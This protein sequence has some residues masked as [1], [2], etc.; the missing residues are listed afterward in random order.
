MKRSFNAI[1]IHIIFFVVVSNQAFGNDVN[2]DSKVGIDD[3][4]IALQVT[5]G[6][7]SQIYLPTEIKWAGDWE[8]HDRQYNKNDIVS[9]NGTSYI[10]VLPHISSDD[11]LPTNKALWDIV[12]LKGDTGSQGLKGDI[13]L[14]GIQGEKGNTGPQGIQGEKG[15]TGSQGLPPEHQW[16]GT[17]LRFQNTDGSWGSYV[18]L[19]GDKGESVDENQSTNGV[20]S[21]KTSN[22]ASPK[23][24]NHNLNSVPKKITFYMHS[25]GGFESSSTGIYQSN[26]QNVIYSE[27]ARGD[28]V[29]CFNDTYGLFYGYISSINET[30]FTISW[31]HEGSVAKDIYIL[32]DAE[33]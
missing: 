17:S 28:Y 10:C 16:N 20:F 7:Q 13:G 3:A 9:Y 22:T 6:I 30:S 4:V 19:K 14:Q 11:R 24:I 31:K 1:A 27:G 2:N 33:K 29:L 15:D 21:V 25:R 23:E 12:A 26:S 5:S 18:D 32:W 8:S